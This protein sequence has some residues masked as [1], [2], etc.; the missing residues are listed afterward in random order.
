MEINKRVPLSVHIDGALKCIMRTLI[1]L[2]CV[3]TFGLTPKES[4]SQRITIDADKTVSVDE[5]FRIIK[6]QTKEY[7]FIYKADLFQDLPKVELKK[8][9]IR[10]DKLINKS[11]STANLNIVVTKNNTILIK[12]WKKSEQ[13]QVSGTVTDEA[14]SPIPGV[15]VMVKGTTL[16][17]A[18]DFDGNYSINVPSPD[19]VLVFTSVGYATQEITVGNQT[20]VNVKLKEGVQELDEV[21]LNA[22]YYTVSEKERTG[23]ISTIKKGIIDKQPV[24]NPIA[25]MQGYMSG[26][27]IVQTSGV[28]GGGFSIEVRGRNFINGVSDPL[29]IVDGVPISSQ[30][31]GSNDVSG[32]IFSGNVSPLNGINP[33]DI[34][35]IEVLKDADATAIYGSRGAN[36][37]VLI[38][39]KKGKTGKTSFNANMSTTL[40][41]VSHF[42]DLL[43]TQQYLEIRREGI[44]N[45]GFQS[46]FENPAFDFAW[47][48][49]KAWDQNRYTDWQKEL[50][51]GTAY[52]NNAQLSVSGGSSQTQF[53]ISGTIQKETTVFPG[54]A[55]YKKA[56][57]HSNINH[58]SENGRFKINLSTIYTK[59]DNMM[60]R[61]DFTNLAYTLEP[62]APAIFDDEGN[63]NWEN[64]TWNNPLATLEEEYGLEGHTLIS[65]AMLSYTLMPNL[66]LKT[67][68]GYNQYQLD[69]YRTLPSSA[70][71]PSRGLTPQNYSSVTNNTAIRESWIVEPQLDWKRQWDWLKME[72]LIGTTFQKETTQQFVQQGT[73]FPNNQLIRNFSAATTL[74]VL[75]DM[76][77][78]YAYTAIFGRVNFN[79]FDRY[80][81]NLTGRRDGS[82]RFGSGRQFGNFGAIGVAWIFSEEKG[83]SDSRWLSFGKLRGSYGV[84]GSDNIG[85]YRFLDTYNVTGLDYDGITILEPTGIYNPLF[86]WES[87]AKLEVGMELGFFK[88]RLMVNTSWYRNRST[89][90]LIGIPLPATAGFSELTGNFDATVENSGIEL[91]LNST[92]V[93]TKNLSWSSRITMT[94]PKNKLV[95]FDGLET[96]TFANRYIIGQPL[97]LIRLYHSL[98]VDPETGLYQFEDYNGDGAISSIEDKQWIEDFA[99]KFYGGFGNTL[100]L[101]N[102][103]LDFFFQFK[104]QKAYNEFRHIPVAGGQRNVPAILLDRWQEP[105]DITTVQMAS[106][107][108]NV[109]V[110]RQGS[111]RESSAAVSDASFI[112]LRNVS[113]NYR[114][115]NLGDRLDVDVYLQGQ[116]IWTL[117][118]YGGPDP[119]Q[120]SS[121]RLPQ[122]RQLTL[123][124]Q[125]SF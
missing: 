114:V 9:S 83:M 68:L 78:E 92:N 125:I 71:N 108:L 85:D 22:G 53:L 47:P 33:N 8:G 98:G 103:T 39:T 41:R 18:T 60:P 36:G 62:N 118:N 19:H 20:I 82:S 100:S 12:E 26:V 7:M 58:R 35:S 42:M 106:A 79:L 80:I 17:T 10:M 24:S 61:S 87:N 120:P 15:T 2:F 14:G 4:M 109:G 1:L 123:G 104:K 11:L 49:L 91:D 31:L 6:S 124:L 50:I 105:G 34:E 65:N 97:T 107:G 115:P 29:F 116:N 113:L 44:F 76:D 112:R 55:N 27:N 70:V 84:T 30:S 48:D 119:E 38:T 16:G 54:D 73:G 59:E 93:R 94:V 69:S 77:S 57:I 5:V 111:Q 99:P 121:T 56:T 37:V 72:F 23:N 32:Q 86:G 25:A 95:A 21:V 64:N 52:R 110:N 96:S 81:L 28:P 90:Q 63:I 75:D 122:L 89:D 88:D 101:G 43:D 102:L 117:T 66:E 67:S 51:G 74:E 45:D 40:G 46:Y 3:A 13:Q